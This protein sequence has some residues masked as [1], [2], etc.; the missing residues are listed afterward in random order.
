MADPFTQTAEP[1]LAVVGFIATNYNTA[2]STTWA[3]D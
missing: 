2:I 3:K 1:A